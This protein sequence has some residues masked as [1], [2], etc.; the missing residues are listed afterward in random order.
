M[1]DPSRDDLIEHDK[2]AGRLSLR[3]QNDATDINFMAEYEDRNQSGSIYRATQKG[4]SWEVLQDLF[5]VE[6]GGNGRDSD[7]DL[8][9]GERDDGEVLTLGLEIEHDLGFATLTSITGF[10]DHEFQYAEDFDGTPLNI[11]NYAQDQQGDYFEQELRL[12]SNS[13]GP[14]SWYAGASYYREKIDALFTQQGNEEVMCVYYLSYYG[15]EGCADYLAYYGYSFTP[16][17]DGL[18]ERNRVKGDYDGWAAYV[19]LSYAFSEAVDA[20][21]GLRYTRDKKNFK[22]QALDVDSDLGPFFALG[23]TTDGFLEDTRTWTDL[24]PRVVVRY[25]PNADW[26]YYGSVTSGYKSGGFGSFAIFPD[27]PFGTVGVTAAEAG[28]NAF[29]PEEV[30]SYEIG[31]KG[32]FAGGRAMVELVGY[33]Y[34]YEDLQ[35]TVGGQGGGILVENVG[36]VDGWGLETALNVILNEY[37]DVYLS[38]AWADTEARDVAAACGDTPLCEGNSLPELPKFSYSAVLQGQLP[39]AAGAW[40][41]RA[42]MFGQT[43]T[44]GGLIGDPAGEQSGYTEIAL[45]AGYRAHAGWEVLA[46]VENV[47]NELYYDLAVPD[48]GILPAHYVGPSRPRTFGVKMSWTFE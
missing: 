39:A 32:K 25:R 18:V 26:M 22:L 44:G 48:S 38:G 43:K 7:S 31:T 40:I 33:F 30:L 10:K 46:Y 24:S 15:F 27:V 8:A 17:P 12:V 4:E 41:A 37:V 19:D 36:E 1:F 21:L 14:F 6:L 28:P 29:A 13:E 35:V 5:G 23:F 45:R 11:N 2:K 42:E 20:S 3:Y 47:T 9:L 34:S 16:N